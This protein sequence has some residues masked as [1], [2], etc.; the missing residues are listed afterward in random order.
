MYLQKIHGPHELGSHM[1]WNDTLRGSELGPY[2]VLGP[3]NSK[4]GP[5]G[6]KKIAQKFVY[7]KL[8]RY[9]K[10][11][12]WSFYAKIVLGLNRLAKYRFQI[13]HY[14]LGKKIKL[15]FCVKK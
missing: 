13:L 15:I 11:I 14:Q 7:A 8:I 2:W 6:P 12:L 3:K 5:M 1:E 10:V 9:H 4:F